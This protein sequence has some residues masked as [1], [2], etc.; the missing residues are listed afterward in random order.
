M[1]PY[2]LYGELHKKTPFTEAL[3]LQAPR[4]AWI[5]LFGYTFN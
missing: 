1:N 4:V 3:V 2:I 5:A